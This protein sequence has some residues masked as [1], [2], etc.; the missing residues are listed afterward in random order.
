[1][2]VLDHSLYARR[3]IPVPVLHQIWAGSVPVSGTIAAQ[4]VG[5]DDSRPDGGTPPAAVVRRGC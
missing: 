1:M 4:E 2:R 3:R 5:W